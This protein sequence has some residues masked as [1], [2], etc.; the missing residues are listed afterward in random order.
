MVQHMLCMHKTF[1]YVPGNTHTFMYIHM[2]AHIC[3]HGY[4]HSGGIIRNFCVIM[5]TILLEILVLFYKKFY[6]NE[7]RSL[8]SLDQVFQVF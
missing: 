5:L 8:C 2:Q 7:K 1:D 3:L 6:G 4:T